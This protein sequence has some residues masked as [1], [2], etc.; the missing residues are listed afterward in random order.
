MLVTPE[1]NRLTGGSCRLQCG[2]DGSCS[3]YSRSAAPVGAADPRS[4]PG[5]RGTLRPGCGCSVRLSH[6]AGACRGGS[7]GDG[8]VEN[9]REVTGLVARAD[10]G[11]DPAQVSDAVD[12]EEH[13]CPMHEPDSSRC[14]LITECLGICQSGEPVDRR[15][16]EHVAGSGTAGLGTGSGLGL[17]RAR[18]VDPH[19]PPSGIRPT[20]F[21]STCTICPGQRATIRRGARLFPS[22]GSM[23]RRRC[24]PR[25][26]SWRVT[27]RTAIST[28]EASSSNAIRRADHFLSRRNHSIRATTVAGV[29]LGCRCGT[30]DRSMSP[31]SP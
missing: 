16:Q 5:R 6:C 23:N 30:Y 24:S 22:N 10:V 31:D 4:I 3:G 8:P 26:V 12:G 1:R 19:P 27:V 7:A 15:M 14:C 9:L 29:A 20:F 28:P 25:W 11:D 18:T 13:S 2:A 21:T 17:F